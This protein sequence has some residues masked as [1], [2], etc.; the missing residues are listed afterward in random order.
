MAKGELK[1]Q[2]CATIVVAA[3]FLTKAFPKDRFFACL[4][5]IVMHVERVYLS[6]VIGGVL[7]GMPREGQTLVKRS[8]GLVRFTHLHTCDYETT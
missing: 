5:M 8:H 4:H 2:Q 3:N 7:M 1:L 6:L